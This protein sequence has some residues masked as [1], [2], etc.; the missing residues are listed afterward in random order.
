[1]RRLMIRVG[2]AALTVSAA[3]HMALLSETLSQ[4]IAGWPAA[5]TALQGPVLA[6]D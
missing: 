4:P 3:M 6:A 2:V 5:W 1:M